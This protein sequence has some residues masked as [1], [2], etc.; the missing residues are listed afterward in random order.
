MPDAYGASAKVAVFFESGADDD[1]KITRGVHW[2]VS[3]DREVTR[4]KNV[5]QVR[6]AAGSSDGVDGCALT[7][8]LDTAL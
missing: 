1:C 3:Q 2:R 8:E 6:T 4:L 7:D 5:P